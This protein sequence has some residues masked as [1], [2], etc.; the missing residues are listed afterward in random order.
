MREKT[1]PH[2]CH[3]ERTHSTFVQDRTSMMKERTTRRQKTR[4]ERE[5]ERERGRERNSHA[6]ER[7][8]RDCF[9]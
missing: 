7:E 6:G 3:R 2:L 5:R 4:E 9:Y 8:E 1:H